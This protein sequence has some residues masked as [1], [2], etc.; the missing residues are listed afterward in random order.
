MQWRPL[1]S[2][3]LRLG[4]SY[5][6]SEDR[7]TG[8]TLSGRATHRA[9]AALY[10]EQPRYALGLRGTWVDER[11]FGVELDS[12]GPPTG[13]GIAGAYSLFDART[14]WRRFA[15]LQIAAGVKNLLDE[16]DPRFLPIQPRSAYLEFRRDF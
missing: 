15:P 11:E 10:F 5:L 2:L 7:D 9:N 16:G 1:R 8:A 6:D 3:Q 13:A 4:Y 14:E 12:G